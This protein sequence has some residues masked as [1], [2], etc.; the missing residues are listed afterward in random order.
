MQ[1]N[2]NHVWTAVSM[3]KCLSST[4]KL[5]I[6]SV[7]IS[8]INYAIVWMKRSHNSFL[9]ELQFLVLFHAC[10]SCLSCSI[11]LICFTAWDQR[12]SFDIIILAY[13]WT[14]L[15]IHPTRKNSSVISQSSHCF[16]SHWQEEEVLNNLKSALLDSSF[17]HGVLLYK[18]TTESGNSCFCLADRA[19]PLLP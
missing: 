3:S 7:I 11:I 2:W 15:Q 18:L 8:A 9:K 5:W 14:A 1:D 12:L 13:I 6:N 17:L 4:S 10:G 16:F 19:A